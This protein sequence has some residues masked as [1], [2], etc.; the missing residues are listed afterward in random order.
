[1]EYL[2][3]GVGRCDI[4]P[5]PGT[6]QGGWGAQ[7]H[8]RGLGADLPFYATALVLSDSSKTVAIVD[9][10]SIGFDREL[11]GKIVDAVV[12]L[13]KI[14][15]E[16][17]RIS[18]T[19]THSGPNTYRLGTISEGL[20]MVLSYLESLPLR[21]AGAVWQA[22]Q[23]LKPVRLSA[24]SG[25]CNINVNRRLKLPDG[26]IVVGKNWEGP[27]DHTV[28]V[29]RVDDLDGNLLSTIVHYAC[30]GTTMA[31]Q[32]QYFTPDYP[33]M[34]K[35]VVEQQIGGACL[36]L[37]GAAGNI[38]PRWGFTGELVVYHRLGKMLGAEATKI[39]TGIDTLPC[40]EQVED[41]LESG[42]PIALYQED[43][44]KEVSPVLR[45]ASRSM[46]LPARQ[47]PPLSQLEAEALELREELNEI[48]SKGTEHEIRAATA[49]ATQGGWR[50]E[51]AQIAGGESHVEWPLLGIR[52]G[53][54][55]LLSIP[56]EPSIEI[57][58]QIVAGSPFAHTLF[59]GYSNGAVGY[60]PVD[61]T[62]DEGGY[63]MEASPFA[64]GAADVVIREGLQLLGEL[65]GDKPDVE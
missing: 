50:A 32:C 55:A 6:P 60:L 14:P 59:S 29:V 42:A 34:T 12:G 23:R 17:I 39:A 31:W 43:P 4:T 22:Q 45:V 8:Q 51:C 54:V 44:I 24:D 5:A 64:R 37:Q 25:Q 35:R 52:V 30:H 53:S 2:L 21:I 10:D 38:T 3:A 41:V 33:G 26:R 58:Q 20:D 46:R 18:C 48:R 57:S 49:R 1:M 61:S 13:T 27:V 9:V 7:T 15:R 36:F 16:H 65:A 11:T 28:R 56:G 19:H 40:R 62:F 47:F 63:E